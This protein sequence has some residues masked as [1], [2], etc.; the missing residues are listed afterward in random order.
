MGMNFT[1]VTY[2]IVQDN[3]PFLILGGVRYTHFLPWLK[4][5]YDD[6]EAVAQGSGPH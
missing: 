5:A 6:Y 2:G 1:M 4:A 3:T